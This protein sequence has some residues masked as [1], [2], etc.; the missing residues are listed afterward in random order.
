MGKNFCGKALIGRKE[1]MSQVFVGE[2]VIPVTAI[3]LG[4]CEVLQIRTQE[5]DGYNAIQLGF[6]AKKHKVKDKE[7]KGRY[8]VILKPAIVKE[9]RVKDP[10]QFNKGDIIDISYFEGIKFVDVTGWSKGR[11]FQ[12]TMKRWGFSGA[13][14][15][16]GQ[17]VFHRRPGSIGQ[18]TF[19]AKVW[20]GK[21]MAGRTGGKK[22]T[23]QNLEVVDI[24]KEKNL[25]L[26]KGAVPGYNGSYVIVREAIRKSLLSK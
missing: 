10:T 22:V 12:G 11:G 13:P 5:R 9:F 16:H 15:S 26:V 3:T 25:M 4:P 18:H 8:K 19:P 2:N 23:V 6:G 7:N 1:G 24:D 21:K 20:K 14:D 17:S